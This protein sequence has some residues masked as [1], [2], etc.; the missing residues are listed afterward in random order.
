MIDDSNVNSSVKRWVGLLLRAAKNCTLNGK[1]DDAHKLKV[2]ALQL[3]V[4]VLG[5]GR[6]HTSESVDKMAKEVLDR[7]VPHRAV[8][9]LEVTPIFNARIN[10][11]NKD[12][13]GVN[14]EIRALGGWDRLLR[15]VDEETR[16]KLQSE[17][18]RFKRLTEDSEPGIF[19][20]LGGT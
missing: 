3:L 13:D 2:A 20:D 10:E 1:S 4:G 19:S 12:I 11:V 8:L 15:S 9:D 7:F 14:E 18:K 17:I 5:K 16:V 6:E